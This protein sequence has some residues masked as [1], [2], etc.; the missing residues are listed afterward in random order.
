MAYLIQEVIFIGVLG[1][2]VG[3]A[4]YSGA[5]VTT[6][7]SLLSEDLSLP[8]KQTGPEIR[9]LKLQDKRLN[10]LVDV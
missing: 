3:L 5:G 7:L 4:G 6:I 2:K 10:G 1:M 8:E 9:Y